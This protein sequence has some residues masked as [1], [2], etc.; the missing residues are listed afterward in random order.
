MNAQDQGHS[1]LYYAIPRCDEFNISRNAAIIQ[2]I[3]ETGSVS[4]GDI[5]RALS[6]TRH[7]IT[8]V[9]DRYIYPELEGCEVVTDAAEFETVP[10]DPDL[11]IDIDSLVEQALLNAEAR[12]KQ[13]L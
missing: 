9:Q 2:T 10:N 7:K 11:D 8:E 12:A 4:D 6:S 1:A 5:E 13:K 3:L